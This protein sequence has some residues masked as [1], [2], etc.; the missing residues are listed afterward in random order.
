MYR[1]W[2]SSDALFEILYFT[3]CCRSCFRDPE[4]TPAPAYDVL[5][6]CFWFLLLS[7]P[8]LASTLSEGCLLLRLASLPAMYLALSMTS[9]CRYEPHQW[10]GNR[11]SWVC[12]FRWERLQ[13]SRPHPGVV[14][15]Y[16]RNILSSAMFAFSDTP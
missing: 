6:N 7:S 16:L 3:L 11:F 2:L 4:T 13:T 8:M 14:N 10:Q 9:L 1:G 5:G 15:H 12:V